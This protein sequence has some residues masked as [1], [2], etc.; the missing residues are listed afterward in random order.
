MGTP[1][2][3]LIGTCQYAVPLVASACVEL[4]CH[5]RIICFVMYFVCGSVENVCLSL[6]RLVLVDFMPAVLSA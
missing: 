6:G 3:G 4:A 2:Q 1:F 5:W